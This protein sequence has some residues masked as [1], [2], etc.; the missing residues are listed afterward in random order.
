MSSKSRKTDW[1]STN[2]ESEVDYSSEEDTGSKTTFNLKGLSGQRLR[3]AEDSDAGEESRLKST[4]KRRAGKKETGSVL[5]LVKPNED[6]SEGSEVED[7]EGDERNI[8]QTKTDRDGNPVGVLRQISTT[9]LEDNRAKIES[10][11][12][13]YLSRVPP[14][15][16]PAKVRQILARFGEID[17]I[18][19]APE[20]PRAYA[21]RIRYGGNKKRNFTEGWVE[22]KDKKRAKLCATTLNGQIIGGNK[23]SF[24]YD[25]IL[26]IKYL[27]K[28]KW[29]NLTEQIAYENQSRQS[30]LRAEI[31]QA[32]RENKAFI[33]S[34]EKAKMIENIKRKK[35][36]RAAVEAGLD[37]DSAELPQSEVRRHFKQRAVRD[38]TKSDSAEIEH[39]SEKDKAAMARVLDGLFG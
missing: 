10:S 12:V 22:F 25:D 36:K 38:R 6:D 26:N 27:P 29:H 11:G 4:K 31:A 30:K 14:F 16:K 8:D 2:D 9:E 37:P 15:M 19:L 39:V 13:V 23:R 18:F 28:F 17:R 32:T 1:F 7:E 3:D 34:V 5:D 33:Q 24:Y 20:D 21:R 35:A